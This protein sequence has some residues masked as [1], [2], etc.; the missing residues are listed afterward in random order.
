VGAQG[1]A[2]DRG[3]GIRRVFQRK[4][5]KG[6]LAL[7]AGQLLSLVGHDAVEDGG[8][9]ASHHVHSAG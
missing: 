4:R 1:A 5:A 3:T 8:R 6:L 2:S 9:F 7:A